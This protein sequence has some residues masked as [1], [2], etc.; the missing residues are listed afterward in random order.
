MTIVSN[1]LFVLSKKEIGRGCMKSTKATSEGSETFQIVDLFESSGVP[2]PVSYIR[3]LQPVP[4]SVA[5]AGQ[6]FRHPS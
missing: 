6:K 2:L 4:P 5:C 3:F 1:Y